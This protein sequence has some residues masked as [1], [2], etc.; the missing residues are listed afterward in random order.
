MNKEKLESILEDMLSTGGDFAE[1][2]IEDKKTTVFS[3]VNQILDSYQVGF[4]NGLG[5]RLAKDNNV[6]YTATNDFS[7]KNIKDV[8]ASLKKN[9]S[10]KKVYV[11]G[12]LYKSDKPSV[13]FFTVYHTGSC[14]T[15][16]SF[17]NFYG[18][19]NSFNIFFIKTVLVTV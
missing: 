11:I 12:L 13:Y 14:L 5:L 19:L 17:I 2:F 4:S 6:Y 9:I 16:K 7:T 3:F 10:G 18:V 8:V 15:V 1:I